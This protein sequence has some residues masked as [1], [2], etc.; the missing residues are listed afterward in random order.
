[1]IRGLASLAIAITVAACGASGPPDEAQATA[2]PGPTAMPAGTYTTSNFQPSLTFTVPDG[3]VLAQDSA[4]YL[5]LRPANS[6]VIGIHLFRD[7]SAASQDATCAAAPEPGVGRTSSELAAWI[8]SLPGLVS[9]TP[10]MATVGG[11]PGVSIDTGLQAEWAQSCP[12]ANGVPSVPLF[13]SPQI[14]HWVVVGN[15][16][17][18]MYLLDVPGG[19]TVV[20]DLDAFDGDQ[21]SDLINMALPIIQTFEFGTS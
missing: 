14:D 3:W 16:R 21:I 9:S 1:M 18:R 15:E 19:G 2:Q 4:L 5:N 12:F 11:L 10:A 20:V 7:P 6:D 17:L 8:R 13:N